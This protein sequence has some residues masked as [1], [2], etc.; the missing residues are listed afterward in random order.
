MLSGKKLLPADAPCAMRACAS[1]ASNVRGTPTFPSRIPQ[2]SF[3]VHV[4]TSPRLLT[5]TQTCYTPVE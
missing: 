2:T 1:L 4:S 5:T 3:L